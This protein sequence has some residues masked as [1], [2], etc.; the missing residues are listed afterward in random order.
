MLRG[1]TSGAIIHPFFIPAAHSLGM[2]FCEGVENSPAM[3]KIYAKYVQKSL[4]FLTEI[5]VMREW[6][7]QA[8]VA[9]WI[10]M[11][12]IVMRLN[13]VTPGYIK[14]G[15]EAIS[16]GGLCFVPTYERPPDFSDELH[17]KL[18]VLSQII[19][20][21]NFLFL[22]RGGAHPTMTARIE[23]EFRRK[24]KVWPAI[25]PTFISHIHFFFVGNISGVVQDLSVD[26]AHTS[27][28]AGQRHS[29]RSRYSFD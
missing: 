29:S 2:H 6:E 23:N 15:C 18:T 24:L 5:L 1:D 11:G 16:L 10:T 7:L 12:S 9:L 19:Y 20:F 25:R 3:V 13:Y 17:E 28:F 22:T 8:Q 27:H 26:H 21:E 14:K 4:E